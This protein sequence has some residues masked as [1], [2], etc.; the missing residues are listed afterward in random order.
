MVHD[1]H[2]QSKLHWR[3]TGHT[4]PPSCDASEERPSKAARAMLARAA[5][6][7]DF[8]Q[9]L[10][11]TATGH[12]AR[13]AELEVIAKD[14][15]HQDA[16]IDPHV[17]DDDFAEEC[18]GVRK[19]QA[20]ITR[21]R[22]R[23]EHLQRKSLSGGGTVNGSTTALS[24][25][26]SASPLKLP[27]LELQ[28]FNGDRV[29]WQPFWEQFRQAVHENCT[30]SNIER[31]LYLRAVLTGRAAAAVSDIQAS[32]QNYDYAIKTLKERFGRQ[33][34]LVQEHL[35]QLLNL[36]TVKRL[37]D[38]NALRRL[39][40]NVQRNVAGLKNLGVQPDTYGAMLC[41]VL[42]RV[43]PT[44]WA[45]EFHKT[46]ATDKDVLDSSTLDAILGSLRLELDSRERAHAGNTQT[47][48][49]PAKSHPPKDQHPDYIKG[50]GSAASLKVSVQHENE[51]CPFCDSP[52]HD[53]AECTAPIPIKEKK[54]RLRN[55]ARCYRCAKRGH[56]TKACRN[57][58]IRCAKCGRRH[59]TSL[60]DPPVP[61]SE[62]KTAAELHSTASLSNSS[63]NS[64]LLQTAQVWV[65][66][67]C[68]KRLARCLF[69]GGS[70]R[71]FYSRKE[72]CVEALEIEE[73]CSDKMVLPS[74][75]HHL[76]GVADLQLA[77]VAISPTRGDR[78]DIEILIGADS[79]WRIV[80][81]EVRAIEG[82]LVALNT[83]F[84]WTLQGPIPQAAST[85]CCSTVAVL[86]T[87][88]VE[89]AS[90][91][92]NE[93]R[94]S[95]E[96]ESLGISTKDGPS[97][98]D[99]HVR[100]DFHSLSF[101]NGRYESSLPWKPLDRPCVVADV[102]AEIIH[103]K[104][105]LTKTAVG[106]VSATAPPLLIDI[107]RISDLNRLLRVTSW[108]RRFTHNCKHGAQ[109]RN[110]ALSAE[111]IREARD[112]LTRQVQREAFAASDLQVS[113]LVLLHDDFHPRHT[114]KV[115]RIIE[116]F[117]G[118]DGRTHACMIRL[119]GG[120]N[121]LEVNELRSL[122]GEYVKDFPWPHAGPPTNSSLPRAILK[123]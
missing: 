51:K 122:G 44:E 79:Y 35:T 118:R 86:R 105:R 99:E 68:R 93:L 57:W 109:R 30:L 6:E 22:T 55:A 43:L 32:E 45:V 91:L 113:D 50:K 111:E 40:D 41:A 28:K 47:P 38:V 1:S 18:A 90:S 34:V 88:V 59:I 62:P 3:H 97:G 2:E 21:M 48:H 11:T 33:D 123:I 75:V 64:V 25:T 74:D 108:V 77:D 80:S 7:A 56:M 96:L 27:K 101:V 70:Q 104:R 94:A 115:G 46:H 14:L 117:P 49:E 61:S 106:S 19:Y 110:G 37:D 95:W 8:A 39:H 98:D 85:V 26:S 10:L 102:P 29:G 78:S 69:D 92:S 76:P 15:K 52:S 67:P 23:L 9:W 4:L 112:L 73:I 114:W 31:F 71:S 120:K 65:D 82:A 5:R 87:G 89:P 16:L 100:H 20:L 17:T 84:G 63:K 58:T 53:G 81:G 24:S 72:H 12:A 36:Q 54:M 121:R 66:G 107:E 42:F 83:D 119:P 13:V 60:C 116:V 103:E